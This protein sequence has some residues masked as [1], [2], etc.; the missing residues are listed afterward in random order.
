MNRTGLLIALGIAVVV[1][2]LFAI[3]PA[4]DLRIA[5]IFFAPDQPGRWL[6]ENTTGNRLR[7]VAWVIVALVAAPA[8]IALVVKLVL[9]RRPL[10]FPGRA[11]VLMLTTL[12]VAPGLFANALMKDNWSR[13]RPSYVTEFGRHETFLPWW[14]PRG[15]CDKNC[16]FVAG[17]PSGAFWTL[18]AAAV[19]PPHWRA[20][21]YGAAL[22]FG[23]AVGVLRMGAGA[24]FFTD[25]VFAGV[26]TF[27]IIWIVHGLLYRW[28][29]T[30]IED[31]AVERALE[32]TTLPIYD[33][34]AR[35]IA[36]AR[37]TPPPG[38]GGGD[39]A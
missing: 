33:A 27:L 12:M 11:I 26:F 20:V 21:A 32:R 18:A 4:L 5:G 31:N 22:A 14:D 9:P 29:A 37:R 36:R 38:D 19:T 30:R 8:V 23:V 10:K 2:V 15:P 16:S 6:F 7:R 1:G 17:E 3:H 35:L 25:V 13:P 24:H 28:R 34:I 39:R